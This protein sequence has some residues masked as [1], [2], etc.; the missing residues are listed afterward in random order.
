[1]KVQK[2]KLNPLVKDV[3]ELIQNIKPDVPENLLLMLIS[4]TFSEVASNLIA[5]LGEGSAASFFEGEWIGSLTTFEGLEGYWFIADSEISFQYNIDSDNMLP[6]STFQIV[7]VPAEL[8]FIQFQKLLF[9]EI[10]INL[11][12]QKLNLVQSRLYS[13]LH[14]HKIKSFSSYLKI[15]LKD[16]KE[17]I[18]MINLITTNETYFFREMQHFDF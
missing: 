12:N 14:H 18:E 4:Y 10:G 15:V 17:K 5:I 2:D 11:S 1:M 13:R 9:N 6:R 8:E 7:D 3:M 16:H